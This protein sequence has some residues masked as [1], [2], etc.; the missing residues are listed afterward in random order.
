MDTIRFI[1]L[2]AGIGGTRLGL[3]QACF[4]LNISCKCVFTSEWD[5]HAQD[6][7][8]ANF[9]DRPRGDITKISSDEIPHYDI[10]LAGFPCQPF[11]IIGNGKGFAD[12]RGTLFFEIERIL[13]DKKPEAFLLENVKRLVSHDKH[14]T[15]Q[16]ILT[17]L[18]ELGYYT[19][20]KILNA[21]DYGLPQKRE[22]VIIVGFKE[23]Y[24]FTFPKPLKKRKSLKDILE[25]HSKVDK[26]HFASEHIV[27]KRMEKTKGKQIP[28]PSIWHEN[29]GGNIGIHEFSCALRAGASYNY[30][31][32]DGIRRLT[33]RE[34][35]LLQ[36]F[37]KNFKIVSESHIGKLAGN[38]VPVSLIREIAKS[39]MKAMIHEPLSKD[40]IN[41]YSPVQDLFAWAQ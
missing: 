31:L 32:V 21:L 26:K 22:R 29:K 2:F 35:L 23:N 38:A 13:R 1:D 18:K 41:L 5:K 30:L 4:D 24:L 10:L 6:M 11:S 28:K 40:E 20:W 34:Q 25:D 33:P 9:G 3:E 36:G 27:K 14:R 12:T 15:F 19:H 17:K 8:E 39:M 7:Y 16:I 37:P